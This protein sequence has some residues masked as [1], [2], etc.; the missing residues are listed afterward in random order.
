[1]S[2]ALPLRSRAETATAN[3]APLLA[4]AEHLASAVMPGGH[5]RRRAGAGDDFWQYRPMQAGDTLRM[6]DWRRS[7]RSDAQYVRQREW[8]I[9]QSV[10]FW[11][12][13]ARSMQFASAPKLPQK[14]DRAQL[15]SLAVAIL[16]SRGGERIGLSGEDLPPRAGSKQLQRFAELLAEPRGEDYATPQIGAVT[17]NSFVIFV[18]DFL[19]DI[20]AVEAALREASSK[21]ARGVCLQVLDP[22]EESFPFRGRAV[23]NSVGGSLS[24]ETLQAADLSE[25]YLQRLAER[26]ARLQAIC[27]RTGWTFATHHTNE[28]AQSAVMWLYNMI[29]GPK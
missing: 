6:V 18:S 29:E 1:M 7:A 17:K 2:E 26:K 16:L 11:V 27:Q 12:D 13:R 23:F 19:G 24:H 25:R 28:S 20:D 9:S 15:V 21:G 8:Q 22:V 4:R 5:G 14:M 3:L 10:F